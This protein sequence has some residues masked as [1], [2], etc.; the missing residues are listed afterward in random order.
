M[1]PGTAAT[2][3]VSSVGQVNGP[4][5]P[6]S[7]AVGPVGPAGSVGPAG[8]TAV[9]AGQF[10]GAVSPP[11]A[12]PAAQV[13][14]GVPPSA[15]QV[16]PPSAAAY[17]AQTA[18]P[19]RHPQ[20]YPA[21]QQQYQRSDQAAA[22]YQQYGG[23]T[24]GGGRP[25]PS[26]YPAGGHGYPAATRGPRPTAA[27]AAQYPY[28]RGYGDAYAEQYAGYG[29]PCTGY[30]QSAAQYAS[31]QYGDYA[32]QNGYAVHASAAQ[33]QQ[34]YVQYA[35]NGYGPQ[36]A[37]VAKTTS[38]ATAGHKM[39]SAEYAAPVPQK[40]AM[41]YKPQGTPEE[42]HKVAE[43]ATK[44]D[45]KHVAFYGQYGDHD[46]GYSEYATG[47]G[48]QAGTEYGYFDSSGG[49][50]G[51]STATDFNFLSKLMADDSSHYFPTICKE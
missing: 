2:G 43:F 22:Y 30:D 21:P 19:A 51:D 23:F 50:G 26:G 9:A 34:G 7:G 5:G 20:A 27:S 6:V 44:G 45:P 40:P 14:P 49:T 47:T 42:V 37:A 33:Q 39:C 8:P 24:T 15:P 18:R 31:M 36:Y 25:G 32:Y 3:A 4:V 1:L 38:F 10:V 46:T 28:Q 13:S 12:A 35:V 48:S 17:S 29:R 11:A 16:P 41:D